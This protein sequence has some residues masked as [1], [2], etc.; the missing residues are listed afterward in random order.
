MKPVLASYE[1]CSGCSACFASCSTGAIS[2]VVDREG[3]SRPKIDE[4]HCVEC[5]A[6]ERACHVVN[7]YPE[8]KPLE[9]YAARARNDEIRFSSS[10]GGIFPLLGTKTIVDGGIV[11]GVEWKWDD[12]IPFAKHCGTYTEDDL[13]KLR[14]SKYVQSEIK[15]AYKEIKAQLVEGK[16]VLFSGTPCQVAGLRHYLKKEYENLICCE[17]ICH[18]VPS[19]KILHDFLASLLPADSDNHEFHVKKVT[20]RNKIYKGRGWR[21]GVVVVVVVV[22]KCDNSEREYVVSDLRADTDPYLRGFLGE[23][24]NRPSCHNCTVR[25]LKSGADITLGDFWKIHKYAPQADDNM[26]TSLICINTEKGRSLYNCISDQLSDNVPVDWAAAIDS[27]GALIESPKPHPYRS[28]F[29]KRYSKRGFE[30]KVIIRLTNPT[31]KQRTER[32]KNRL[33]AKLRPFLKR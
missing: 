26:G 16:K 32:L 19:P 22:D 8:R 15:D 6:C 9:V 13:V 4:N 31:I 17:V 25:H 5:S 1:L 28:K 20:F 27:T 14:G 12:R 18:G 7:P 2:M 29:F 33:K 10:S 11:W 3:F 30:P 24:I 21:N 23:L